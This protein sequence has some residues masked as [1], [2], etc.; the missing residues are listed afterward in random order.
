MQTEPRRP[1]GLEHLRPLLRAA[2]TGHIVELD[3]RKHWHDHPQRRSVGPLLLREFRGRWYVL[4]MME[5]SGRLACFGLDRI[6]HLAPTGRPFAAPA[7]FDPATYFAHAFGIIRPTDGELPQ[8]ILLR[9]TP[10]QGRYALSYPLHSS[11][12]V[13]LTT[14]QEIRLR[15]FVYDTHDL[16]MEL[17]SYSPE[18]T[19]LAPAALRDWLRQQHQGAAQRG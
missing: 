11:Q 19:V 18:V 16:R 8:E 17:L 15:L 2:Q 14:D 10:V 13:L 7:D 9:F 12:E 5:G 3:Y 6:Q 1:L 4:A